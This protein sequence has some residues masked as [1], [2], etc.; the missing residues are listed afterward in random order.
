MFTLSRDQGMLH[1]LIS[2]AFTCQ[3]CWRCINAQLNYLSYQ[4]H[5][6]PGEYALA[7]PNSQE[8][9][10]GTS[11]KMELAYKILGNELMIDLIKNFDCKI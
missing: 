6:L 10:I 7:T 3:G 9:M 5:H 11:C 2:V 1:K 8:T 4:R